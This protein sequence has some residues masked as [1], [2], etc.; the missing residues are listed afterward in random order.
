MGCKG[1]AKLRAVKAKNL[2]STPETKYVISRGTSLFEVNC[3]ILILLSPHF[4]NFSGAFI[5]I[6]T[7]MQSAVENNAVELGFEGNS[8]GFCII[9]NPVDTDIYFTLNGL[10]FFGK[11]KTD[12]IRVVI[13]SQVLAVDREQGGIRAEYIVKR[14][15]LLFLLIKQG[16]KKAF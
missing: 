1:T 16:L 10:P 3:E 5:L 15:K 13:V 14:F 6:A 12:D 8:L 4:F 9:P 2:C 11:F 7:Q